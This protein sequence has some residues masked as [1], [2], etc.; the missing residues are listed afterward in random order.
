M[1]KSNGK[2]N[3]KCHFGTVQAFDCLFYNIVCLKM[4]EHNRHVLN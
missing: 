1:N 4:V 3:Y 2:E